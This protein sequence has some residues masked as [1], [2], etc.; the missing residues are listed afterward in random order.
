[1]RWI[2]RVGDNN[3]LETFAKGS[4]TFKEPP[5]SKKKKKKK[6]KEYV[7]SGGRDA[8]G[9]K[10]RKTLKL[11]VPERI[12][13]QQEVVSNSLNDDTHHYYKSPS[14]QSQTPIL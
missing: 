6:E 1:M 3:F 2:R 12:L 7:F 11:T 9:G 10:T 4:K 8:K 14:L 13:V 5:L